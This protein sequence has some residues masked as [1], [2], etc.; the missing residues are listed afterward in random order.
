MGTVRLY[1]Y[2]CTS[3]LVSSGIGCRAAWP[4][5][6]SLC[7]RS[8][9]FCSPS[10]VQA[11]RELVSTKQLLIYTQMLSSSR[12]VTWLSAATE[13]LPCQQQVMGTSASQSVCGGELQSRWKQGNKLGAAMGI[14]L[15]LVQ[16]VDGGRWE[17]PSLY[18]PSF[19]VFQIPLFA[20]PLSLCHSFLS[21]TTSYFFLFSYPSFFSSLCFYSHSIW[22]HGGLPTLCVPSYQLIPSSTV[23]YLHR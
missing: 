14:V 13:G 12:G 15:D 16:P 4:G 3:E 20:A 21:V 17:K 11:R 6:L 9:R 2:E 7:C 5:A 8:L 23:P 1:C 18:L 19:A 22:V 10:P